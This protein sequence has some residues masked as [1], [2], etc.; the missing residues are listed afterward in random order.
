MHAIIL[1]DTGVSEEEIDKN[2]VK[3]ARSFPQVCRLVAISPDPAYRERSWTGVLIE[4]SGLDVFI[5]SVAHP[6]I[7]VNNKKRT[8][9]ESLMFDDA[10]DQKVFGKVT[11]V[12]TPKLDSLSSDAKDLVI[13]KAR[14]ESELSIAPLPLYEGEG[15]SR[16]GDPISCCFIGY[17]HYGVNGKTVKKS[18]GKK[19]LGYTNVLLSPYKNNGT[20]FRSA[21]YS[22]SL[23]P[24]MSIFFEQEHPAFIVQSTRIHPLHESQ[25]TLC[26]GDSGGPLIF[27]SAGTYKISGIASRC[28]VVQAE[29]KNSTQS[30]SSNPTYQFRTIDTF[31]PVMSYVSWI[32]SII[33]GDIN[34][35]TTRIF[36]NSDDNLLSMF[37]RGLIKEILR[38][39][40]Q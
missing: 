22:R 3:L 19:R 17:G 24:M 12:Y 26:L 36:I 28:E 4:K 30:F 14:M 29:E 6:F 9:L 18:D 8:T 25:A 39:S 16:S 35:E 7:D 23:N 15:R 27:Q 32:K 11:A 10:N 1:K 40:R 20:S 5:L 33:K 13:I 2:S 21:L 37:H 38:A 31:I 34:P